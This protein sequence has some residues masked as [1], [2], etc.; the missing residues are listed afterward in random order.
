MCTRSHY[1]LLLCI[2]C[3]RSAL[4]V[5]SQQ[6]YRWVHGTPEYWPLSGLDGCNSS[7]QWK[8]CHQPPAGG[9]TSSDKHYHCVFKHKK[10]DCEWPVY[11]LILCHIG[12][13]VCWTDELVWW[14]SKLVIY[15]FPRSASYTLYLCTQFSTQVHSCACATSWFYKLQSCLTLL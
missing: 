2:R 11:V 9:S 6:S 7:P 12:V 14:I 8:P 4:P 15:H 5:Q 3:P 10:N 13:C 1:P